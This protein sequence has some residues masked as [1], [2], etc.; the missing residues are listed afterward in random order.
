MR[1]DRFLAP[2][3]L[4]L[5][6]VGQASASEPQAA[7]PK[8]VAP[9]SATASLSITPLRTYPGPISEE[10][11]L[12]F[13]FLARNLS[14]TYVGRQEVV[15]TILSP[16]GELKGFHGSDLTVNLPPGKERQFLYKTGNYQLSSEDTVEL[17]TV[18]DDIA[19]MVQATAATGPADLCFNRCGAKEAACDTRYTCGVLEFSCSCTDGGAIT[20]TCKCKM[21]T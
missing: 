4:M 7:P 8:L 21:C 19:A 13:E 20:Y 10:M 15:A 5:S 3:V 9:A 1:C 17:S 14:T 18:H 16:A 2:W 12:R 6:V 11:P